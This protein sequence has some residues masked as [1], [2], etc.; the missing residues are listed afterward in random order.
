MSESHS[1]LKRTAV[2][3]AI[4]MVPTLALTVYLLSIGELGAT[5]ATVLAIP[6]RITAILAPV[7]YKRLERSH[8]NNSTQI[9]SR[10]AITLTTTGTILASIV[11]PG[12]VWLTSAR[13]ADS[14]VRFDSSPKLYENQ[15]VTVWPKIDETPWPSGDLLFTPK[16]APTSSLGDCL[17]LAELTITPIIDG[18]HLR[19]QKT[20]HNQ[21]VSITI[22]GDSHDVRLDVSLGVPGGQ[23]CIM[24]LS[25]AHANLIR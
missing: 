25:F 3:L 6:L 7:I 5:I 1:S 17:L 15:T 13:Y 22:P 20:R 8:E 11:L 18:Q 23:E 21:E 9:L 16:L 12:A 14:P 19:Q 10:R 2:L 24:S 4:P